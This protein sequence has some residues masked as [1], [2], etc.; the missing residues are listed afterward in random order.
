MPLGLDGFRK[1]KDVFIDNKIPSDQRKKVPVLK[2]RDDIVWVCGIQ[3]D[4]R[5]RVTQDTK[6]ILRCRVE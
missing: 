1:V 3:I 5:Y 2:S 6:K 4:Q